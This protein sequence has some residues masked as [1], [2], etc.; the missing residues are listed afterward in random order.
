ME[1]KGE[2][3]KSGKWT[4]FEFYVLQELI[5]FHVENDVNVSHDELHASYQQIFEF[6]QLCASLKEPLGRN[7]F[8]KSL[9]SFSSTST[10]CKFFHTLFSQQ[11]AYN[12][13]NAPQ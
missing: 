8:S 1:S 6:V 4:L 2:A 13:T 3:M 11:V 9:E 7:L 10:V 12:V 5:S